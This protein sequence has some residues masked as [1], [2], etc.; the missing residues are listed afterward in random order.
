MANP[1]PTHRALTLEPRSLI[2]ANSTPLGDRPAREFS[3]FETNPRFLTERGVQTPSGRFDPPWQATTVSALKSRWGNGA[4][5]CPE[6][7]L[8]LRSHHPVEC[9]RM[10]PSGF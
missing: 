5:L 9:S 4:C 1:Q 3:N 2:S 6:L 8:I 7:A 10:G